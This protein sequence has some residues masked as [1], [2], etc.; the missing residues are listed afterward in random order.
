MSSSQT[1]TNSNSTSK[2]ATLSKAI[3][4]RDL[5][6]KDECPICLESNFKLVFSE[7][8][9]VCRK[10]FHHICCQQWIQTT[11]SYKASCPICRTT[12]WMKDN[13]FPYYVKSS[14][15]SNLFEFSADLSEIEV[16][17]RITEILSRDFELRSSDRPHSNNIHDFLNPNI[18]NIA[19]HFAM[20]T[21]SEIRAFENERLYPTAIFVMQE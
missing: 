10:R 5:V 19:L 17:R 1:C 7:Q 16:N 20:M 21:D 3:S 9:N 13:E 2:W 4:S 12:P 11:G 18:M 15:R 14:I 8:C 6:C